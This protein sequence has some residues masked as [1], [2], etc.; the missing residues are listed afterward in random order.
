MSAKGGKIGCFPTLNLHMTPVD[1]PRG[2]NHHCCV[3]IPDPSEGLRHTSN[4]SSPINFTDFTVAFSQSQAPQMISRGERPCLSVEKEPALI[5]PSTPTLQRF[6]G[7]LIRGAG[8]ISF[9]LRQNK[10]WGAKIESAFWDGCTQAPVWFSA[11][12]ETSK[13]SGTIA[14]FHVRP[15]VS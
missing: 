10:V 8:L 2:N 6:Y 13:R 12:A 15:C 11:D 14:G 9:P 3:D 4:T 5:P 1:E 7:H